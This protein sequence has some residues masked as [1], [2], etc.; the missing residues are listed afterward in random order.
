MIGLPQTSGTD[1]NIL[2][3]SFNLAHYP[4]EGKAVTHLV[5]ELTPANDRIQEN[6]SVSAHVEEPI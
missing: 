1:V 2:S 5:P 6:N 3:A 4:T